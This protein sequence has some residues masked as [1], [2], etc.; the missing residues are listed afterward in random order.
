[1]STTRYTLG[2]A[3]RVTGKNK[4]TIQRA[5]KSGRLSAVVNEDGSYSIEPVELSRVFPLVHLDQHAFDGTPVALQQYATPR[6]DSAQPS[7]MALLGERLRNH[8]EKIRDLEQ[9]LDDTRQQR[10][11]WQEEAAYL[12]KLLPAP[13]VSPLADPATPATGAPQPFASTAQEA[14]STARRP[15]WKRLFG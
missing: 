9:Q 2:E 10:D 4:T 6:N 5:I 11:R 13:T 1:M 15:W 3:A 14:P 12:R 8:E 7:D